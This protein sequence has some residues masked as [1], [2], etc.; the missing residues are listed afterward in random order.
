[1]SS[2]LLFDRKKPFQCDICSVYFT[3]KNNLNGHIASVHEGKKPFKCDTCDASFTS[4]QNL[5]K[6]IVSA[7]AIA[8]PLML[9]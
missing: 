1:M 5:N 4:K 6:H 3:K 9:Q 2:V 8:A 7:H